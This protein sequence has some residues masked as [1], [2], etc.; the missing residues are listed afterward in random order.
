MTEVPSVQPAP[1]EDEEPAG[2]SMQRAQ[3]LAGRPA[4]VSRGIAARRTRTTVSLLVVGCLA[5]SAAASDILSLGGSSSFWAGHPL[6]TNMAA[7]SVM[8]LVTVVL[9]DRYLAYLERREWRHVATI[10]FQDLAREVMLIVRLM[11]ELTG[12]ADYRERAAR[13]MSKTVA[14]ELHNLLDKLLGPAVSR[15][16][17]DN[18]DRRLR[19]LFED[20]EWGHLAYHAMQERIE[21]GRETIARWAPVMVTNEPLALVITRVAGVVHAMES[22]QAT[23]VE[24]YVDGRAVDS[25]GMNSWIAAWEP[26]TRT[27]EEVHRALVPNAY[28]YRIGRSLAG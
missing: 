17:P 1:E 10:A 18:R 24:R 25:E 19:R 12:E 9:V 6:V 3:A 13:P 8:L 5:V 28:M 7:S 23:L 4:P 21:L 15:S 27:C 14:Q 26:L 22:I 2:Q 20:P 16:S 11:A